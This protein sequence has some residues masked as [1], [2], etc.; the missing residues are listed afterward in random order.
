MAAASTDVSQVF[1]LSTVEYG[2]NQLLATQA[3]V[4]AAAIWPADYVRTSQ[5]HSLAAAASSNTVENSQTFVLAACIGRT[6]DPHVRAWMYTLDGHDFYVLRLGS[7]ETLVYD[8]S[9]GTWST[10]A[11]GYGALW[12]AFNGQNWIG[13]DSISAGY[14]SN[15]VVG[16]DGNGA[17]YFL[18]PDGDFDDDPLT[19]AD[20]PR[21]YERVA[22]GQ[23]VAHGYD[24]KR[25]FGATIL[26]SIGQ[27]RSDDEDA[28]TVSLAV[29]DDVGTSY[30]DLGSLT[31]PVDEYSTR[32]NW[33]SIGSIRYPGRL[34]K[35]SDTGA[36]KRIDGMDVDDGT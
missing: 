22:I 23:I 25:C 17:L 29:S 16:D 11:T 7:D 26:G 27:Q 35:V 6:T 2:S 1:T 34:F 19:G 8:V 33:R 20:T 5:L 10:F 31:I 3:G 24:A 15:I 30:V 28:R 18:D 12:R 13:A 36:L 14:G 32:L 9:T 4:L 21:E